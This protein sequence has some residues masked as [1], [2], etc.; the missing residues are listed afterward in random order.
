MFRIDK[1]FEND[2]TVLVKI[3]GELGDGELADW[4]RALPPF[5]GPSQKQIIFDIC[6]VVFL[7]PKALEI[8]I[9]YLNSHIF[10]LNC[11][12]AV[13]NIMHAAGRSANVLD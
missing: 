12:A 3:E 11:P 4:A 10:L 9:Q 2:L 1:A 8:F 5:T 13:R 6:D 7:S